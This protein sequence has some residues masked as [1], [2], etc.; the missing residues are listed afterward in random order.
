MLKI[1]MQNPQNC[2]VELSYDSLGFTS[3]P[4]LASNDQSAGGGGGSGHVNT[5]KF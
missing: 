5:C 3:S 2:R 4:N 1:Y